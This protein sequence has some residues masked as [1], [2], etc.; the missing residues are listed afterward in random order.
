MYTIENHA[1]Q[2]DLHQFIKCG[3]VTRKNIEGM[4]CAFKQHNLGAGIMRQRSDLIR[5]FRHGHGAGCAVDCAYWG[6]CY[7]K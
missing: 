5:R 6:F 4:I 7:E 1:I 3:H 2:R